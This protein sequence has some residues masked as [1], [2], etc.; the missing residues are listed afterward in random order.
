MSTPRCP[1]TFPGLVLILLTCTGLAHV[2]VYSI[3]AG[4]WLWGVLWQGH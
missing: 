2:V 4:R 3:Q 1:L